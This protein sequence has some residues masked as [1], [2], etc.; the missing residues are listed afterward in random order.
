MLAGGK[1]FAHSGRSGNGPPPGRPARHRSIAEMGWGG[2]GAGVLSMA[3]PR[4]HHF[5]SGGLT[6][7]FNLS[8]FHSPSDG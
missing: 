3:T 1:M 7:T 6:R 4:R 8:G 2:F 5:S